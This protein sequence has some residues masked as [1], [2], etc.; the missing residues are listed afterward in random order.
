VARYLGEDLIRKLFSEDDVE[1]KESILDRFD[2]DT[3]RNVSR[4]GRDTW[5]ARF[6]LK[7]EVLVEKD[8]LY[9]TGD[10]DEFDH[11]NIGLRIVFRGS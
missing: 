1:A 4:S 10:Q 5:E 8:V 11:Y 7:R 6:R 3:G 2:I 9:L